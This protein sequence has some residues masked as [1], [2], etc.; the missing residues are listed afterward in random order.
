MSYF[1]Y[2]LIS[3]GVVFYFLGALG[4]LRMPDVWNRLQAGTKATTIG[5]FSTILGVGLIRPE[6]FLKTLVLVILI[7]LTNPVGS[8]AIARAAY[9]SKTK[10]YPGTAIDQIGS[11][12]SGDDER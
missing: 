1:G 3:V 7:A 2:G 9:V 6:W 12:S 5:S 11:L 8:S 4:I 10:V